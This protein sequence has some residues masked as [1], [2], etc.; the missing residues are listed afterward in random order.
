MPSDFD[1]LDMVDGF[2]VKTRIDEFDIYGPPSVGWEIDYSGG[3]T[4]DLMYDLTNTG[5]VVVG[6]TA[7]GFLL[8]RDIAGNWSQL[9]SG[10][11]CGGELPTVRGL[12]GEF[13]VAHDSGGAG[14]Q[15]LVSRVTSGSA[16][17][18]QGTNL[19]QGLSITDDG[20][21]LYWFHQRTSPS[22][23]IGAT[24]TGGGWSWGTVNNK[25]GSQQISTEAFSGGF[26]STFYIW[27]GNAALRTRVSLTNGG[28]GWPSS[29]QFAVVSGIGYAPYSGALF[30]I[31]S[32]GSGWRPIDL[33][34]GSQTAAIMAHNGHL[35]Y[36]N[37]KTSGGTPVFEI[38]DH[39]IAAG[40][41][42]LSHTEDVT[43]RNTSTFYST[44]TATAI[45]M[46]A[47]SF[48]FRKDL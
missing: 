17:L 42:V 6:A 38:L 15:G 21:D 20:T 10:I 8:Y 29:Y 24:L 23:D 30:R 37:T 45:F 39:D 35:Y 43:G 16:N 26:L 34:G 7:S 32:R 2:D 13:Y 14:G 18:E 12:N 5:G 41:T 11:W 48:V 47:Y 33:S 3:G 28:S 19:L 40:T 31:Q 1:S 9:I 27:S 4:N 44:K 36:S 22:S 46:C 25:A